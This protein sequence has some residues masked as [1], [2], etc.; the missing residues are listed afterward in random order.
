MRSPGTL[1][2]LG[3]VIALIA[4]YSAVWQVE[5]VPASL[6]KTI[7]FV[8]VAL[9]ITANRLQGR[10]QRVQKE[11]LDDHQR[12]LLAR[13]WCVTIVLLLTLAASIALMLYGVFIRQTDPSQAK[14]GVIVGVA[15]YAV[16]A[17]TSAFYARKYD[18]LAAA[19]NVTL[20]Q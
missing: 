8:G 17:A 12:N 11:F 1:R 15:L 19:S 10:R 4:I 9:I 7:G 20:P 18:E 6:A 13:I 14:A 16:T 3:I 2:A 5:H